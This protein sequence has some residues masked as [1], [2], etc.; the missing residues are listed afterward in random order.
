M[1]YTEWAYNICLIKFSQCE[2]GPARGSQQANLCRLGYA[3]G[4]GQLH[5]SMTVLIGLIVLPC[6]VC[7]AVANKTD[8]LP[9]S[10]GQSHSKTDLVVEHCVSTLNPD[11]RFSFTVCDVKIVCCACEHHV[12]A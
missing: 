8:S 11:H 1:H 12:I 7:Y 2:D 5:P 10:P 4:Q 9:L 3:Q 6:N